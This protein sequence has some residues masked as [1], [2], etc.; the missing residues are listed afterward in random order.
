MTSSQKFVKSN[1]AGSL[2]DS[3]SRFF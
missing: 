2:I 1:E 3:Q